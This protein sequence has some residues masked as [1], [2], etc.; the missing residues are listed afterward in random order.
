[1]KPKRRSF[2]VLVVTAALALAACAPQVIVVTATPEASPVPAAPTGAPEQVVGGPGTTAWDAFLVPLLDALTQ[3]PPDYAALQSRM[4]TEFHILEPFA[5][6]KYSPADA[7]AQFG[8][9]WLP[10]G[11]HITYDMAVDPNTRATFPLPTD[12]GETVY[13]TGWVD[14]GYMGVLLIKSTAD[15]YEWT[16]VY[17]GPDEPQVAAP[18]RIQ[19][20]PGATSV[21]LLGALPA[22]G[23]DEY[24]L[25]AL[26]GQTMTVTITSPGDNV[27][28]TIYGL[29]D[30]IPLVR[31]ASDATS[32][33][34]VLPASQDYSIK[35][36]SAVAVPSYQLEVYVAPLE[37]GGATSGW[38]PLPA[39][40][41][42]DLEYMVAGQLGV[43]AI[44]SEA[45]APF[46]DTREGT[47]G[48][49]CLVVASGTGY[50]FS[51]HSDVF[52]GLKNMLVNAGWT[53][54]MGYDAGGPTGT[55]GG[56]R[57]DAALMLLVVGWQPSQDAN[58]PQDQPISACPLTP[59][60]KLYEIRLSAAMR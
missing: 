43:S 60:Q 29:S 32:W 19:F 1:M 42:Q 47:Y 18:T 2:I 8:A 52:M 20:D 53:P 6:E 37:A 35:A 56:F 14:G 39:G 51:N 23:I 36:V 38:I 9:H 55:A 46:E 26:G 10:A 16:G 17:V 11:S 59:E 48:R 22:G 44:W 13:T 25:Y 7:I 34:G 5:A 21:T 15:G 30:G 40:V 12:M 24:L 57:R 41:C 3:T 58:C 54:D 4:S 49:G 31:S 45:N 27:Y 33:T 28:L 50:D